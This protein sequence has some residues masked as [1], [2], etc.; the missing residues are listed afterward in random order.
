MTA[1]HPTAGRAAARLPAPPAF[2]VPMTMDLD[3]DGQP[4]R[5]APATVSQLAQIMADAADLFD[6]ARSLQPERLARLQ[7]GQ[8]SPEDLDV[9]LTLLQDKGD[10][11]VGLVAT[12]LNQGPDWVGALLPDRFAY[13]FAAAVMVNADFFSQCP[14]AFAAAGQLL[15]AATATV[16]AVRPPPGPVPPPIPMP[17]LPGEPPAP[18]GPASSPP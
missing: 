16:R 12:L 1:P 10:L 5:V 3:I 11:A 4:V 9:L 2:V 17:P 13:L 7:A 8:P 14:A 15:G 6:I 18:T